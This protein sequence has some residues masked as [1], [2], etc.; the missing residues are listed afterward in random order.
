MASAC[1]V[2]SGVLI[3]SIRAVAESIPRKAKQINRIMAKK[4]PGYFFFIIFSCPRISTQRVAIIDPD[5]GQTWPPQSKKVFWTFWPRGNT[6]KLLFL[7][8]IP[9]NDNM[10]V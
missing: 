2:N 5:Y 3:S 8:L 4:I 10:I 9:F 6:A 1:W 7:K